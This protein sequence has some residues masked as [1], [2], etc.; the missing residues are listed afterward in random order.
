MIRTFRHKGLKALYEKNQS[1]G[2]NPH[3]LK[4]NRAILPA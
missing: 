2:L 4:R 3:W 1:K